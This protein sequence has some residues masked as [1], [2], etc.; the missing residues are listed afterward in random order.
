MDSR[1]VHI[2]NDLVGKELGG[3]Q[4]GC[5]GTFMEYRKLRIHLGFAVLVPILCQGL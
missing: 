5:N 3:G 1:R 4:A 2:G